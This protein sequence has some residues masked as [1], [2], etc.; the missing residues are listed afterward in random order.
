MPSFNFTFDSFQITQTRSQ[1]QDTDH[2]SFTLKVGSRAPQALVRSIGRVNKGLH[3]VNLSFANIPVNASDSV[4]LNYMIVNS[5]GD[6]AADVETT[7]VGS[8]SV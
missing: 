1:H 4:V 5:G 3:T 2:V 7:M 6:T 8:E